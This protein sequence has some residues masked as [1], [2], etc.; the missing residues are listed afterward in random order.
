MKLTKQL[1]EQLLS[2]KKKADA[3]AFNIDVAIESLQ[4]VCEHEW[5]SDSLA[6]QYEPASCKICG[7]EYEENNVKFDKK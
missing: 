3:Y 5:E 2:E 6:G 7:K 4:N 1:F